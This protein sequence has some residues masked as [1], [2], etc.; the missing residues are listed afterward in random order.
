MNS[1]LF[2]YSTKDR[3]FLKNDIRMRFTF[4]SL[5]LIVFAWQ[6]ISMFIAGFKG[7]LTNTNIFV[8]IFAC[9]TMLLFGLICLVYLNKSNL[10][11]K[12]IKNEGKAISSVVLLLKSDKKSFVWFYT[13]LSNFLAIVMSLVTVCAVTYLVLDLIYNA[14]YSFYMPILFFVTICGFNS[15]YHIKYEIKTMRDVEKSNSSY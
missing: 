12:R 8:G 14:T 13:M 3:P 5:F 7:T 1:K 2:E 4:L 10:A 11:I 15:V 9:L 6:L